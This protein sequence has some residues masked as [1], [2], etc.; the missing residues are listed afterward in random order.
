[1]IKFL[2]LYI[3]LLILLFLDANIIYHLII[4]D[5]YRDDMEF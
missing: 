1:M 3:F 2:S 4:K 5:F